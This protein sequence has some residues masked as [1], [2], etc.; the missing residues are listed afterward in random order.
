MNNKQLV[1]LLILL[2]ALLTLA[3]QSVSNFDIESINSFDIESVVSSFDLESLELPEILQGEN[4][5]E[6]TQNLPELSVSSLQQVED[7]GKLLVPIETIKNSL[8]QDRVVLPPLLLEPVV[9]ISTAKTQ[10]IITQLFSNQLLPP[11]SDELAS[12]YILH[13]IFSPTLSGDVLQIPT[14]TPQQ[15]NSIHLS[16]VPL[17]TIEI[18]VNGQPLVGSENT[19]AFPRHFMDVRYCTNHQWQKTGTGLSRL[20]TAVEKTNVISPS[21]DIPVL[22]IDVSISGYNRH[23]PRHV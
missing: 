22:E 14:G 7:T 20:C 5:D 17:K 1:V 3:C 2:L 16:T 21:K 15:I 9:S 8:S 11:L 12:E 13:N 23:N 18:S 6:D 4:Q 10:P 19:P